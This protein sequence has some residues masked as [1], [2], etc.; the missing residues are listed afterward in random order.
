MQSII[1]KDILL[2]YLIELVKWFELNDIEVRP[3]PTIII[4]HDEANAQNPLGSTGYYDW[5]NQQIA[6]YVNGR[7]MKDI[8]RSFCHELVHHNQ[9]IEYGDIDTGTENVTK[10][11]HLQKLEGDAYFRGNMLFR[12]WENSFKNTY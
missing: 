5:Q 6:L 12:S 7:N 1:T 8:L 3:L 4:I 10:S 11:K 2:P 9:Y